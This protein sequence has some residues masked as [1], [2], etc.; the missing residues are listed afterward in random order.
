M[1]KFFG[2]VNVLFI[3]GIQSF[4]LVGVWYEG[5]SIRSV[6]FDSVVVVVSY[7]ILLLYVWFGFY[8]SQKFIGRLIGDI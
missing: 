7:L 6:Y 1:M 2:I 5:I 8:V 4:V 3:G